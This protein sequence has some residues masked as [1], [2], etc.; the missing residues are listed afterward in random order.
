M[1]VFIKARFERVIPTDGVYRVDV[2]ILDATGIDVD[3]LV[4]RSP[5][6][7]FSHV[8]TVYDLET[9]PSS[10]VPNCPFYRV[11][12]AKVPFNNLRDAGAFEDVTRSRLKVLAVAWNSVVEEF[13]GTEI[14][15]VES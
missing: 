7:T 1:S 15:V 5:E 8:A 10:P 13:T 9:Y 3:L 2:D 4:F 11:R 14:V 12:G 6:D